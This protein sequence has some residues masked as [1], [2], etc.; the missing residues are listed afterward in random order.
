MSDINVFTVSGRLGGEPKS[1]EVNGKTVIQFRIAVRGRK[2]E[3]PQWFTVEMWQPGGVAQYLTSGTQVVVSGRLEM[4]QWTGK[5]GATRTDAQITV[6][7][8]SLVGS[9]TDRDRSQSVVA[10]VPMKG[11]PK[12]EGDDT[13]F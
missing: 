1:K 4:R 8:L 12:W 6:R 11:K 2:A 9:P 5:D 10:G 3:E 7:D 13:P